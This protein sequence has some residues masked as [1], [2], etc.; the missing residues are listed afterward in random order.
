MAACSP[1]AFDCVI[2]AH[3]KDMDTLRATVASLR[4][5]F[6]ELGRI[7]VIASA[8]SAAV[9]QAVGAE[10]VDEAAELWP[11]SLADCKD[12]GCPAGWLLQQLL[13]LHAPLLIPGLAS[14]VLACDADVIWL[15]H[16]GTERI[17][18]FEQGSGTGADSGEVIANICTF[19][20]ESCPP[21]RSIV[22]LHRYDAF[23]PEV[24]PGLQKP[25]PGMESAVCHHAPLQRLVLE[26][27]FAKVEERHGQ[28]FWVA[29][30]DAAR[31]CGG[32]ASEYELYHSFVRH[33]FPN[34][35]NTRSMPF[36]VVADWERALLTLP[37]PELAFLVAHSH[38]RHLPAEE[39]QDRE[40]VI[41]GNTAIEVARRL[42]Q[43]H[44]PEL[45]AILT[46]SGMF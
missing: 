23:V 3:A 5:C 40:G 9:A 37:A 22:D 18:F 21:I 16:A 13:K 4:R 33:R 30:R 10:H 26:A 12:C 42:T 2:P 29:F 8:E 31:S 17:H 11:F 38:L 28:E 6:P 39:L 1:L 43:R 32:R 35:A 34:L 20:S 14:N 25:R 44:D 15:E 19:D 7:V 41:N 24:L 46:R 36:A 45:S 27:L